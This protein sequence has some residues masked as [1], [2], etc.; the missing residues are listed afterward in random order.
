MSGRFH[1]RVCIGWCLS[2]CVCGGR[3]HVESVCASGVSVCVCGKVSY[4]SVCIG[5]CL[6]QFSTYI[7]IVFIS[8]ECVSWVLGII[9]IAD[10]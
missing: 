1:V 7:N 3:F 9:I 8:F 2:V 5:L 10:T 6:C 4:E